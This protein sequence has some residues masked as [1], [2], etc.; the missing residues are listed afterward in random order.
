MLL[1]GFRQGEIVS[2][3]RRQLEFGSLVPNLQHRKKVYW[4]SSAGRTNPTASR[5]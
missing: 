1:E 4:V 5:R 3:G 2:L